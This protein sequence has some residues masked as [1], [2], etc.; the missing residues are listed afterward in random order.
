MTVGV[1]PLLMIELIG[2]VLEADQL[3]EIEIKDRLLISIDLG[4]CKPPK[5]YH[6]PNY[7]RCF[8]AL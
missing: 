3:L 6:C 2:K 5:E 8:D 7:N 4:E 1:I